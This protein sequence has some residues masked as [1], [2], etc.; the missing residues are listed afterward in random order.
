[1]SAQTYVTV[2]CSVHTKVFQLS[3]DVVPLFHS[4]AQAALYFTG[5]CGWYDLSVAIDGNKAIQRANRQFRG[6]DAPTDTLSFP[7]AD[8]PLV[9]LPPE[10]SWTA[11]EW[12]DDTHDSPMTYRHTENA[13]AAVFSRVYPLQSHGSAQQPFYLG[14][15]LM[16]APTIFA[17]AKAAEHSELFE[18]A[19]LFTHSVL[20]LIGFDDFSEMGYN[21]MVHIQR[22]I[23][24]AENIQE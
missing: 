4:L 16:S 22:A 3:A 12:G 9:A 21:T 24:A 14:D 8:I 6:V 15:I 17:Q 11:R 18:I 19:F 1:M 13:P 7:S 10:L 2:D 20:H 5:L 23:L